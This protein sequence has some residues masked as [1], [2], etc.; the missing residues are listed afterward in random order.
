MLSRWGKQPSAV[1]GT[2]PH[3]EHPI[4]F[5]VGETHTHQ[6]GRLEKVLAEA[7]EG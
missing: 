1:R 5:M 2:K 3:P 4:N 6:P 7:G